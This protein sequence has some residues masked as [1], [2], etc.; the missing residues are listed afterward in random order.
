VWF[1][2]QANTKLNQLLAVIAGGALVMM[3]L[4]T[5]GNMIMRAVYVPFGATSEVVGWLAAITTGFALGYTQ[6]NRAHVSIDLVVDRFPKRLQSFVQSVVML[7]SVV[8]FSFVTW[9]VFLYGDR[10]RNLG[11]LSETLRLPH[12]FFVYA[13][14]LG[15]V[16][17][18]LALVV[19]LV[20][21][22]AGVVEK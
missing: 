4:V 8:F 1:L 3:M 16:C 17:L 13:V 7:L 6:L 15:I 21:S 5:V 22:L 10:L 11:V 12:Y 19:D 18:T 2:E 14:A 20:K 9:Q